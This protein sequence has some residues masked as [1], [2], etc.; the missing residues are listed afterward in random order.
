LRAF[1]EKRKAVA[2]I[3]SCRLRYILLLFR[4]ITSSPANMVAQPLARILLSL[5][6]IA[7]ATKGKTLLASI[8]KNGALVRLFH[9]RRDI[10]NEH[11]AWDGPRLIALTSIGR[12]TNGVLATNDFEM[13][14]LR[15][16]LLDENK[17]R[18]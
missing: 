16:A 3:A 4:S 1:G 14:A 9:P 2:N 18:Q 17:F 11:F 7:I 13:V 5:A 15:G 8:Q 10:W 12:V 6:S